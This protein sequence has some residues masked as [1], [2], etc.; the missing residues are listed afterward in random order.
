MLK[1]QRCT[2]SPKQ[3]RRLYENKSKPNL[4]KNLIFE[5]IHPYG[6]PD[7]R[8]DLDVQN[9][10][11]QLRLGEV[12]LYPT[13]T[14]W[15]LG[16][17]A[18]NPTAV[19]KIFLMKQ[20]PS[21]NALICL[22]SGLEMLHRYALDIPPQAL[23]L[24]ET[25]PSPLTIIYRHPVGLAKNLMSPDGTAGIRVVKHAFCQALIEAFGKPIASTSAN[26]SGKPSPLSFKDISEEILNHAAYAVLLHREK[27]GQASS[28]VVKIEDDRLIFIRP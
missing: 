18:T 9:C 15:G 22:V 25:H 23:E 2:F 13:D 14:I 6:M 12:I 19:E 1:L 27:Q 7:S 4:V 16:C 21:E 28:S 8:F 20:R 10:L 3:T 5:Q 24:I 17:D 11:R 26:I